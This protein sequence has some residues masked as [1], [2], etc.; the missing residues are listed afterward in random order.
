[1]DTLIF[2]LTQ[3]ACLALVIFACWSIGR[4]SLV[5]VRLHCELPCGVSKPLSVA[6]GLG[7]NICVLQ[8][9]GIG[10]AI[11]KSTVLAVLVVQC[12]LGIFE[13]WRMGVNFQWMQFAGVKQTS[14]VEKAAWCV[15]VAVVGITI[16]RPLYPPIAWDELMYHL[17]HAKQWALTGKLQ[18]NDWLR[19]PWFP[20][21]FDLLYVAA[22]L[23]DN[24]LLTHLLHA[25]AGWLCAWL[26]YSFGRHYVGK[27]AGIVSAIIWISVSMGEYGNSYVD[28]GVTV[29]VLCSAIL[30]LQWR[31]SG[32]V[33]AI[34]LSA[35][36][37]GTALGSKYQVL[38]LL[39]FY[40]VVYFWRYND[41][42]VSISVLI[43]LMLPCAYWYVRNFLITGD[44]VNPIGGPIFG[45]SDWNLAD[46]KAQFDDLK[47]NRGWPPLV[48]LLFV[49]VPC[50][51][52]LWFVQALRNT[53]YLSVYMVVAWGLTSMYP[54]YLF[55]AYPMLALL[56][57]SVVWLSIARLQTTVS[58]LNAV[59]A[60]RISVVILTFS[61]LI[62]MLVDNAKRWRDMP[63]NSEKRH[64]W[65][66]TRNT[67]YVMWDYIRAHPQS[68]VYQAGMEDSLYYAPQ[69]VWGEIF[70][71]WR[72]RDY[73]DLS[74]KEMH[75]RLLH[76]KFTAMVIHS[77]RILDVDKKIDFEKY[78]ELVHDTGTVK[79]Y[80]LRSA[81]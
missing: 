57:G 69:P 47:R 65:L 27:G 66:A 71:P 70:G 75:T 5:F 78:F 30:L 18:I 33:Q 10:G 74:A 35:F 68:K 22:L 44:P 36:F 34:V 51:P 81:K 77:E 79:L 19:Y 46:H 11:N 72:Y 29:F 4:R 38:T 6:L 59:K 64:A 56:A 42:K 21:N 20:Y 43:Y 9:L 31:E 24:D 73:I 67:S 25:L 37:L 58:N 23:F 7:I 40:A 63:V 54:R 55:T 14:F 2:I 8:W 28:M 62:L 49:C 26:I 41:L 17:P 52:T 53:F 48:L 12:G 16:L 13:L 15:L 32:R 39:P 45:F 1:M 60:A 80:H 76:E 50:L 3:Y 61:L